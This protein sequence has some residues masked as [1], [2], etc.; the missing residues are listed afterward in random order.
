MDELSR[1]E[2]ALDEVLVRLAGIVLRL[3]QPDV[4]RSPAEHQALARSVHHYSICA[5]QSRDPR[6]RHLKHELEKT[7][8]PRLR[9]VVSR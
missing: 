3:A 2:T 6:V 4:T 9:I 8:R 1:I 5:A 7:L